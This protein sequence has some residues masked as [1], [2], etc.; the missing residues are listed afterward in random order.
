MSILDRLFGKSKPKNPEDDFKVTITSELVKI[1][2]P[3]RKTEQIR[4]E[5][6]NEIRMITTSDGPLMPDVWLALIG[7]DSGCLIP[8]GAKGCDSVYE[9]VSKYNGFD[10]QEVIKSMSSAKDEQFILWKS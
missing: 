3:K 9:I 1:E 4:W 8:Q 6:I 10:F 7:A 5:D 2:H